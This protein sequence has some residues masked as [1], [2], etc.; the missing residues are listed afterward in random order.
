MRVFPDMQTD[1]EYLSGNGLLG[2]N[3]YRL[4]GFFQNF[5]NHM[6]VKNQNGQP[7]PQKVLAN[8]LGLGRSVAPGM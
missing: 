6:L 3:Q 2:S 4:K 8:A 5:S 1:A 7:E